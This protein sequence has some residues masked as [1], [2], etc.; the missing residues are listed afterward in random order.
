MNAKMITWMIVLVVLAVL[1]VILLA[2]DFYLRWIEKKEEDKQTVA[3]EKM[4]QKRKYRAP[5]VYDGKSWGQLAEPPKVDFQK[6]HASAKGF[7]DLMGA[8][9]PMYTLALPPDGMMLTIPMPTKALADR[10]G[11]I[12]KTIQALQAGKGGLEE[13]EE[14]FM[15]TALVLAN[16]RE[17][18][19]V[20]TAYVAERLSS[21]ETVQLLTDY[22]RWIR[23]QLNGKN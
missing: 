7:L 19:V 15:L 8:P 11:Q 1:A 9:R 21:D 17:G 22:M 14:L 23:E 4:P 12:G 2:V 16:N 5:E 3:A 13:V 18:V 10:F 20:T 6:T